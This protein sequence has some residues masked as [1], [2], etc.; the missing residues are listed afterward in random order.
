MGRHS[1]LR[2]V[3]RDIE[4][5]RLTI[6]SVTDELD[7]SVTSEKKSHD[8]VVV[9]NPPITL[10]PLQIHHTIL[11]LGNFDSWTFETKSAGLVSIFEARGAV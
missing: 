5:Q 2:D 1:F 11:D 10:F 9:V 6:H 3:V 4:R 8:V 7:I